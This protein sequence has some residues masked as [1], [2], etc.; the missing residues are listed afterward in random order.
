MKRKKLVLKCRFSKTNRDG[1]NKK[2]A[3]VADLYSFNNFLCCL[4]H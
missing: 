4:S 1:G 3:T 2:S